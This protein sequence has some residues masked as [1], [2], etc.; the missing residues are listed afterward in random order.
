MKEHNY[1]KFSI[2]LQEDIKVISNSIAYTRF[3]LNAITEIGKKD[4]G[5]EIIKKFPVLSMMKRSFYYQSI[6][7]IHKLFNDNDVYSLPKLLNELINSYKR[8]T[9]FNPLNVIEINELKEGLCTGTIHSNFIK[10]KTIRDEYLAH[11]KRKP[12]NVKITLD[13]LEVLQ[14]KAEEISNQIGNALY[15]TSTGYDIQDDS[16]LSGIIYQLNTYDKFQDIIFNARNEQKDFIDINDLYG[17][18]RGG[19]T[20]PRLV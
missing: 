19:N 11:N 4:T 8:I 15:G 10:V 13:E 17:I 7:E 14:K 2:R 16:S 1:T 5:K 6:I 12:A 3:L 20:R 9:W 18:L